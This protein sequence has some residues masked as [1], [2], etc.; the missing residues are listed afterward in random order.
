MQRELA[1]MRTA[2]REEGQSS[3]VGADV[4]TSNPLFRCGECVWCVGRSCWFRGRLLKTVP[5]PGAACC[6]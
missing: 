2:L 1:A 4:V 3:F 5:R 6:D